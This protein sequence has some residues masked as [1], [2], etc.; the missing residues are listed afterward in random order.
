M[1]NNNDINYNNIVIIRYS[2]NQVTL[3]DYSNNQV[4][5]PHRLQQSEREG[6]GVA[7]DW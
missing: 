4:T 2:N 1:Y 5:L 6:S 7:P 3:P